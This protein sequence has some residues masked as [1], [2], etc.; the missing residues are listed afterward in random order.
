[1]RSDDP[2]FELLVSSFLSLLGQ[3][4][5]QSQGVMGFEFDTEAY[6]VAVWPVGEDQL[7]VQVAVAALQAGELVDPDW[8]LMLH[9]LNEDARSEHGWTATIDAQD[10]LLLYTLR[11]L[12][13]TDAQALQVAVAAG[14]DRAEA[15][16]A[17]LAHTAPPQMQDDNTPADAQALRV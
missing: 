14:L 6:S 7:M 3:D 12:R 15:L 16:S 13:G 8:L 11:P 1:M 5:A 2:A 9:R 10:Q 4:S 17:M